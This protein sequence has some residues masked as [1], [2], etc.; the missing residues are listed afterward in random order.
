MEAVSRAVA[1]RE[2]VTA[3]AVVVTEVV[4]WK[5]GGKAAET[6]VEVMVEE[7]KEVAVMVAE[8]TAEVA[9]VGLPVEVVV[10]VA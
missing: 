5:V 1:V 6:A 7:E 10:V 9:L 8:A 3:E 4:Y 2:A